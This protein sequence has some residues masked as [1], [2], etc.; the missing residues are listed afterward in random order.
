MT[1]SMRIRCATSLLI[2]ASLGGTQ[3]MTARAAGL[4]ATPSAAGVSGALSIPLAAQTANGVPG[5]GR[6]SLGFVPNPAAPRAP[7]VPAAQV[8]TLPASVDLSQYAPPVGD[9]G[10]VLSC[11][12]W[13]TGYGLRGWYA[14]RDGYYPAGGAGNTGSYEPMYLYSQIVQGQNVGT[15]FSANLSLLQGG[16]DTRADYTQGDYNYTTLPTSAETTNASHIKLASYQDVSGSNLQNWIETTLAGGNPVAVG[17]PDYP[18]FDNA[19]ASNPLVGLPKPGETSRGNH[20]VAAFKYDA[21]GLWI[22]NSWGTSYGQNGWSELS[23][24]FVNQYVFEAVSEA[25]LMPGGTVPNVIYQW[26]SSA[27]SALRAAGFNVSIASAPDPTCNHLSQVI[28]EI[29]GAG[30]WAVYGSTVT[31]TIGSRPPNPCP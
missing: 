25:P 24:S 14:K 18:E 4:P 12:S 19:S 7:L 28:R 30:T 21:N 3:V 22:E 31:I 9:Q 15:S 29:P 23:W 6:H 20:A 8:A 10:N 11:V 27:S 1:R 26:S 16:I 5:S 13:A 17:L 2:F